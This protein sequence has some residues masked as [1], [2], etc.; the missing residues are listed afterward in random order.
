MSS[1]PRPSA[2]GSSG[3]IGPGRRWTSWVSPRTLLSCGW[4][5]YLALCSLHEPRNA[6][7]FQPPGLLA[8]LRL[9]LAEPERVDFHGPSLYSANVV[10]LTGTNGR[11]EQTK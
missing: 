3:A 2:S 5:K 7:A 8:V 6:E 4:T 11:I 10:P 9:R 1:G